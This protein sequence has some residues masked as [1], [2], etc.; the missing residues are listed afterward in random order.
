MKTYI[1]KTKFNGGI[2]LHKD[3]MTINIMDTDGNQLLRSTNVKGNNLSYL[4]ELIRL[5][6]DDLTLCCES[7][8]NWYFLKDYSDYHGIDFV[9]GIPHLMPTITQSKSKNDKADAKELADLLRSNRLPYG[10]A[11]DKEKRVVRDNL[12][13]RRTLVQERSKLKTIT[14]FHLDA[15]M[16]PRFNTNEK[17]AACYVE[18][19]M[20]RFHN[21]MQ[22]LKSLA[23][24]KLIS[25]FDEAIAMIEDKIEFYTESDP[26]IRLLRTIPGIGKVL[27]LMLNFEIGHIDRFSSI[28]GFCSYSR[29]VFPEQTS[30][31]KVTGQGNRKCGNAHIKWALSEA[32]ILSRAKNK[33][34]QSV[35]A[36]ILIKKKNNKY[37]AMAA[38]NHRLANAVY[39]IMKTQKPF[40]FEL[41]S[42]NLLKETL[43]PAD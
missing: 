32:G 17:N 27:S 2:D 6:K 43:M 35:Y 12:R 4:K 31:G 36:A 23:T 40:N 33:E 41:F 28:R 34:M 18:E 11:M 1:T 5:Y 39:A 14:V 24:C 25:H 10:F 21:P 13:F 7:T 19:L 20:G 29:V 9:L 15:Y 42:G 8:Y 37:A 16:L 38:Y 30:N 22:K 26:N 3:S